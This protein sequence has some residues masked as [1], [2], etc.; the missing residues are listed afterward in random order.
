VDEAIRVT[1]ATAHCRPRITLL[2]CAT[3]NFNVFNVLQLHK[4]NDT[5]YCC[6]CIV[7]YLKS[8]CCWLYLQLF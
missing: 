2:Y 7:Q 6:I 4:Y 8:Y 5:N 3:F 1:T